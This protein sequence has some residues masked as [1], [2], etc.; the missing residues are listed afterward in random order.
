MSTDRDCAHDREVKRHALVGGVSYAPDYKSVTR[1]FDDNCLDLATRMKPK[2][3]D[4]STLPEE[5]RLLIA[6]GRACAEWY[7]SDA[8]E[9][10]VTL[11]KYTKARTA[12][13]AF[14]AARR[15]GTK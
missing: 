8:E 1:H 11:D 14:R 2:P 4:E 10:G 5:T 12:V 9:S 7:E 3:F 6:L 15:A 13:L